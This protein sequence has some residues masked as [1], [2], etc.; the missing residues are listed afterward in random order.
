VTDDDGIAE[1]TESLGRVLQLAASAVEDAA[2]ERAVREV[3]SFLD[4][5][6]GDEPVEGTSFL[7]ALPGDEPVAGTVLGGFVGWRDLV[8]QLLAI[9]GTSE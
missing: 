4:A 3:A 2:D 9:D 1:P 6:A 7:D 8:D 5:L